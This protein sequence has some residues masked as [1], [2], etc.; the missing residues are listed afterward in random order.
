MEMSK[1]YRQL[2]WTPKDDAEVYCETYLAYHRALN[3]ST[4]PGAVMNFLWT[5]DDQVIRQ[6][7]KEKDATDLDDAMEAF[8]SVLEDREPYNNKK[9]EIQTKGVNNR[10]TTTVQESKPESSGGSSG[11]DVMDKLSN[12]MS[13]LQLQ[14][15]AMQTQNNNL[16]Q[17][18]QAQNNV[19]QAMQL[20][21]NNPR[22]MTVEVV[23]EEE[24]IE[25]TT[26]IRAAVED[27]TKVE[28]ITMLLTTML[29]ELTQ[30]LVITPPILC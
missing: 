19:M 21:F 14:V 9:K 6:A 1:Q 11:G 22:R 26:T 23:A 29:T 7:V 16:Q 20:D 24:A 5:I 4:G 13:S 8:K 17:Q 27:H 30:P 28:T 2:H 10:A 15:T 3:M 18:I 25:E 12:M